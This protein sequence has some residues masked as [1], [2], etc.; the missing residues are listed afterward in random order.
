VVKRR[1]SIFKLCTIY[2]ETYKRK[3]MEKLVVLNSDGNTRDASH[4]D[5]KSNH[6]KC[7]DCGNAKGI[8]GRE[9]ETSTFCRVWNRPVSKDGYCSNYII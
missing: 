3:V 5:L 8:H 9:G 7:C 4:E 1:D 6:P 2:D